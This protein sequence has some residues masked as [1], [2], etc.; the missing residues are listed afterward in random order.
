M[1]RQLNKMAHSHPETAIPLTVTFPTEITVAN[2]MYR[3]RHIA[4]AITNGVGLQSYAASGDF[5]AV[6]SIQLTGTYI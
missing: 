6:A 4:D 3:I 5:P 2:T 1:A